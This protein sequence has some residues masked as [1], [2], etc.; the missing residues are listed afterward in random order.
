MSL[1]FF[2]SLLF[3]AYKKVQIL[4]LLLLISIITELCVEILKA[5]GHHYFILYHFFSIIE[6]GLVTLLLRECIPG[7]LIKKIMLYSVFLFCIFSMVMSAYVQDFNHFPTIVT[8]LEGLLIIS[9][10]IITL[11]NIEA[12]ETSSIFHQ[13]VFWFALSFLIYFAGTIVFNSVYNYLLHSKTESAK[14]L[15][16]II[17]SV[18]NYLLYVLL[19]IGI[20]CFKRKRSI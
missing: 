10:S 9:W 20:L 1:C 2:I 15:F 14:E 8:S 11:W 4:S 6:Y 5:K 16:S 18:S 17:N 13:P 3:L 12:N 7:Y 19:I